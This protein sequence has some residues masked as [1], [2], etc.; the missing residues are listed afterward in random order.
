MPDSESC[1][2]DYV[3]IVQVLQDNDACEFDDSSKFEVQV[4]GNLRKNLHFWRGIGASPFILSF[5]KE[6][7]KLP[8][9]AF[10][11]PAAFKNNR[12][13]LEHEEFVKSAL[14]VLCQSGRVIRYSEPPYVVNPL[15][16][17]VQANGKKRLILDLRYVNRHLQKKR[18]KYEDWKV[19]VSYFEVG[20]YMFT[21]DL[22]SG[23]HHIE[24]ATVHRGLTP[25]LRERNFT[26]LRF[27]PLGFP[28]RHIPSLK[29]WGHLWST[30]G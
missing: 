12:S 24:V 27:C 17:S 22:N 28:P 29:F 25:F 30:G 26:D 21:F 3:D 10:P 14:E 8:F 20:A 19:A 4:K 18:M 23:Y 7:Y 5:V 16:V 9:F 15:S 13:A 6:E 11:E 2:E 1:S